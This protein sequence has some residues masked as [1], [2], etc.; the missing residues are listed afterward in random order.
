MDISV[1]FATNRIFNSNNKIT[2]EQI[3]K[4]GL[5]DYD[6]V[7]FPNIKY[8]LSPDQMS[9]AGPNTKVVVEGADNPR[10]YDK[11]TV[12][13]S[14]MSYYVEGKIL[15]ANSDK[16][17]IYGDYVDILSPV[18]SYLYFN[19]P[20]FYVGNEQSGLR[21]QGGSE[22]IYLVNDHFVNP[23]LWGALKYEGQY[24][25]IYSD[26]KN[27][28]K[29]ICGITSF[30]NPKYKNIYPINANGDGEKLYAR[31]KA[32]ARECTG[33]DAFIDSYCRSEYDPTTQTSS[34][35]CDFSGIKHAIEV[36]SDN[37]CTLTLVG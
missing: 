11:G 6:V 1:S 22:P 2:K 3:S 9:Q 20:I 5:Y 18:S 10:N 19:L 15:S 33:N 7:D 4:D 28:M 12:N 21:L 8:S 36:N 30:D 35:S 26:E 13:I 34:M 14:A 32:I 24:D 25:K 27:I 23:V 37:K 31:Y 16:Q 29:Q 17:K